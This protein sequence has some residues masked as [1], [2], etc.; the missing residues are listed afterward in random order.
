MSMNTL[1][2][3]RV[4]YLSAIAAAW[5]EH[6]LLTSLTARPTETLA[7][8]GFDWANTPWNNVCRLQ[9]V[10]YSGPSLEWT[11]SEWIWPLALIESLT[12]HLPLKPPQDPVSGSSPASP[13]I[14]LADYYR[15]HV[16]FFSDDWGAHCTNPDDGE[17]LERPPQGSASGSGDEG[18]IRLD[19]DRPAD[20]LMSGEQEFAAFKVALLGAMAKAWSN[21]PFRRLLLE[22]AAEALHTIRD[23]KMPWKMKIKIK[24][25]QAGSWTPSHIPSHHPPP[26][27]GESIVI[28]PGAWSWTASR[29]HV[30]T[31]CLPR[32]PTHFSDEPI[33]LAAY[34]ATGAAY[35][36]TCTS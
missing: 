32:R 26:A 1:M 13:A 12:M 6:S 3:F 18:I 24:E 21:P 25:D 27:G 36:F 17:S 4:A 15:Q 29:R 28:P 2:R 11:G 16:S 9:I 30:L 14:L 10:D 19:A 31:L 7:S 22:N 33:A 23:Y 8:F 20:G 34:N 35:P 5:S